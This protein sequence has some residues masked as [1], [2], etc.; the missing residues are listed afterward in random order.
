MNRARL[1]KLEAKIPQQRK[2]CGP[3]VMVDLKTGKWKSNDGRIFDTKEEAR[4]AYDP[5]DYCCGPVY[6]DGVRSLEEL[7]AK[8]A[9]GKAI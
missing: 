9:A 5:K 7:E 8:R 3:F 1:Q 2:P 6:V 4:A